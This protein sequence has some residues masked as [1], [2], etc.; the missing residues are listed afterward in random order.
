MDMREQNYEFAIEKFG[1][2]KSAADYLH[3]SPPALSIFLSNLEEK[4]GLKLFDRV[5]KQFLPTEA[6]RL[7]L[8]HAREMMKIRQHY[9]TEL[10]KY[11][12]GT[13]G[14]V[15]FGIHPRRTLHLLPSVLVR[16]SALYPGIQVIPYEE[17]TFKM[18]EHLLNGELDF[19]IVNL[20]Q[21]NSSLV[22]TPFYK[23]QLVAVVSDSHPVCSQK[24]MLPGQSLPWIDLACLNGERFILQKE[25]QSVRHYEDLALAYSKARPGSIFV[26]ENMETS[27][28]MAAEGYGVAFTF[29]HYVRHFQ[30][31]KPVSYFLA[32]DAG[33]TIDYSIV[34]QKGRQVPEHTAALIRLMREQS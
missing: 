29:E 23:D 6:G 15:R 11:K 30:Y 31:K 14:T 3:I 25:D 1:M 18:L 34:T 24:V 16:F 27:C 20:P 5:G 28:Q 13:T 4:T 19:I 17:N 22:Y 7:Y 2:I 32:G 33:I 26:L 12:E 9:E 8:D 21:D 10:Q